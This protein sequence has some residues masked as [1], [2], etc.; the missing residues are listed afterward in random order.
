MARKKKFIQIS[1]EN[2]QKIQKALKCSRVSVYNA[3]AYRSESDMANTIRSLA[4]S[5]YGGIETYKY[6][7]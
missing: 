6:V 3:L 7:L 5:T 4:L 2:V 1:P